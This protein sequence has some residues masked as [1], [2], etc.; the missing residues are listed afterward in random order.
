[1]T[2]A[3]GYSEL[4]D[5]MDQCGQILC[6]LIEEL[7]RQDGIQFQHVTYRVKGADSALKK[8]SLKPDR[9]KGLDDLTD[10]L[11]IRI[12]TYFPHDVDK[13]AA[14]IRKEFSIDEENSVDKRK[15]LNPDKFGYLSL[16]VIA[17]LTGARNKLAEYKRFAKMRFEIQIR[18]VL[19]HAWA[20]I[21]HDLG[22]KSEGA[23]PDEMRRS[24]SRLAGILELADEEFERLRGR[25]GEY[26]QHIQQ[27]IGSAPQNLPI[28]QS[29]LVAAVETEKILWDLDEVIAGIEGTTVEE[30]INHPYLGSRASDLKVLGIENL[31]QL[32]HAVRHLRKYIEAFARVWLTRSNRKPRPGSPFPRGVSLFYLSYVLAAQKEGIKDSEWMHYAP[33]SRRQLIRDAQANW[34]KVVDELDEPDPMPG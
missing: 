17:Y 21:E 6:S 20:E 22:Y 31:A 14:I 13:V 27:T 29:T 2:S 28:D 25:I 23:L 24:F 1:M 18:S 30:K 12:I 8:L 4:V 9:Y 3:Q 33:S 19:Q 15:L 32:L 7:L 11:G 16:H 26:E 10:L 5:G 34:K